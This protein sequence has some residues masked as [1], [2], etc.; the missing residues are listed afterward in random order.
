MNRFVTNRLLPGLLVGLGLLGQGGMVMAD[1]PSTLVTEAR[2][3]VQ[4]FSAAL[5][6]ELKSALETGG[7]IAAIE[8]C[9][10]KAPGI[11]EQVG[12]ATGW[13]VGRTAIKLRNPGNSPDD[14]EKAVLTSFS[15]R[16][17]AG[18]DLAKVEQADIVVKDGHRVFRY[19][20]AIPTAE[21]CV[22]CHGASI[23]PDIKARLDKLYPSDQARGF[24]P[25]SLRGAFTLSKQL[26]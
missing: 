7:P 2:G 1:D 24:S 20:K 5:G 6:K 26:D 8:V 23:S 21:L 25:G 15:G 4:Q 10:L 18:E 11:T 9:N 14:W 19:M 13:Q 16:A 12:G 3:V 17:A 22:T